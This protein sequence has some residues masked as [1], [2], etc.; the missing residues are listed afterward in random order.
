MGR[1]VLRVQEGA[2]GSEESDEGWAGGGAGNCEAW[3][4]VIMD[5]A[6]VRQ[7]HHSEWS[8]AGRDSSTLGL[9]LTGSPGCCRESDRSRTGAEAGARQEATAPVQA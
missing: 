8:R 4:S 6:Q 3:A 1:K 5:Y 2:R 7:E 9:C